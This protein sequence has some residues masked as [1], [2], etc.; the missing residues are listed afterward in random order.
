MK[1]LSEADDW[2]SNSC[3]K[4][5]NVATCKE[6]SLVYSAFLRGLIDSVCEESFSH[7]RNFFLILYLNSEIVAEFFVSSDSD[8]Q[9]LIALTMKKRLLNSIRVWGNRNSLE[10]LVLYGCS[11]EISSVILQRSCCSEQF[12]S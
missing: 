10:F 9:N 2:G 7:F 4:L 12:I 6:E 5:D 3:D 11:K 1:F 8:L